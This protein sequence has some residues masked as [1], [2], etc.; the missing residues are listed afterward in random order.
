MATSKQ[1]TTSTHHT[2][3]N[4]KTATAAA[5]DAVLAAATPP[6]GQPAPVPSPAPA[7]PAPAAPPATSTAPAPTGATPAAPV[8]LVDLPLAQIAS[9][10]QQGVADLEAL[11]AL[12]PNPTRLTTADRKVIAGRLRDGESAVLQIVADVAAMPAY[13]PLLTSLANLDFGDDP[14]AFEP[15]VL[16]ERL[17]K[18]DAL[19]PLADA[20]T[21][22]A[23]DLSDSVLDL[24]ALAR[25]PLLNAYTILKTVAATNPTLK[26]LLKDVINFYTAAAT[27]GV[28]TKKAKAAAASA[29]TP[30]ATA[31][32]TPA[33]PALPAPPAA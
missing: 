5:G 1:S 33:A 15:E 14:N 30:A 9:A 29:A 24:Q 31:P 26:A 32:A 19:S 8:D 27:A 17:E 16:K 10:A 21:S 28:K 22:L 18:V 20:L 11:R 2:T 4:A 12:L 7:A 3:K 13:A 25:Q 23:Q 6:P